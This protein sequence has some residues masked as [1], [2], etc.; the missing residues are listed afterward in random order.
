MSTSY[1]KEEVDQN[2][3]AVKKQI[4]KGEVTPANY[5]A[6]PDERTVEATKAVHAKASDFPQ[7]SGYRVLGWF[8]NCVQIAADH[9][10][11]SN[12]VTVFQLEKWAEEQGYQA[13]A[14]VFCGES[15]HCLC[16]SAN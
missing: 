12:D 9:D 3:H 1:T 8:N 10:S 16:V 15:V 2:Y 7:S 5:N 4:V 6:H 11:P 13:K 14:S